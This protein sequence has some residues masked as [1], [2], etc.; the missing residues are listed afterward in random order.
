M[1]TTSIYQS[2]WN[3]RGVRKVWERCGI[4]NDSATAVLKE[5]ATARIVDACAWF[6]VSGHLRV[7]VADTDA[8]RI[9]YRRSA[10]GF[11]VEIAPRGE[12]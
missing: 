5:W 8:K 1:G 3:P 12:I 10:K 4:T 7:L 6:D 11:T 2:E 9:T